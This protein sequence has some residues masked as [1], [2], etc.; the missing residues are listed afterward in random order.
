MKAYPQAS[1]LNNWLSRRSFSE[2][3]KSGGEIGRGKIMSLP[4]E[5]LSFRN[6]KFDK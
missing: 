5:M 4:L 1:V 3:R 6:A 2:L